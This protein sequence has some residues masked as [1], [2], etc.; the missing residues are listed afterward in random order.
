MSLLYYM[1]FNAAQARW[2]VG[3]GVCRSIL[4]SVERILDLGIIAH[5]I[6]SN[7]RYNVGKLR[8]VKKAKSSNRGHDLMLLASTRSRRFHVTKTGSE[9]SGHTEMRYI[10]SRSVTKRDI[11]FYKDDD[12]HFHLLSRRH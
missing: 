9:A 6:S 1:Y 8:Q 3:K 7:V 11:L 4:D 10:L 12:G 2:T 5:H